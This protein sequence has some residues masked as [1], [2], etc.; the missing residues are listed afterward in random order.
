MARLPQLGGDDG[1]WGQILN[2]FLAVE[3]I[4]SDANPANIGK[5]RRGTEIDQKYAIP[6]DSN[7]NVLGIPESDL[8]PAV[9][10]KLNNVGT[11]VPPDG[12]IT[13]VK[14]KVPTDPS[15][16]IAQSKIAN[17]V[18]DLQG[19]APANDYRLSDARLIVRQTA[20]NFQSSRVNLNF[21]AGSGITLS[22]SDDPDTTKDQ[23]NLQI[24]ATSPGASSP[25]PWTN[26]LDFGATG[27]GA[28]DDTAAFQDAIASLKTIPQRGG[29][30]YA[31][32]GT[33]ILSQELLVDSGIEVLGDGIGVTNLKWPNEIS[34]ASSST[35]KFGLNMLGPGPDIYGTSVKNLTVIGPYGPR[36][37]GVRQYWTHGIHSNGAAVIRDVE[38]KGFNGGLYVTQDHERFEDMKISNCYYGVYFGPTGTQGSQV[39]T[40]VDLTNNAFASVGVSNDGVIGGV[41]WTSVQFGKGPYAFYKEGPALP[42]RDL[43]LAGQVFASC[44]FDSCGNG[45]MVGTN[46]TQVSYLTMTSCTSSNVFDASQR[47]PGEPTDA[48]VKVGNFGYSRIIASNPFTTPGDQG[49]FQMDAFGG[50]YLDDCG[51][52]VDACA[53]A[54]KQFL[55][56]H[57]GSSTEIRY[58]DARCRIMMTGQTIP[59]WS[60]IE[61]TADGWCQEYA[62]GVPVGVSVLDH[63]GVQ[64]V[65]IVAHE[66]EVK[67]RV[68]TS[69]S[70]SALKY[71][72]PDPVN[73]GCAIEASGPQDGA[74]FA[75][76]LEGQPIDQNDTDNLVRCRLLK[77]G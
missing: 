4:V 76:S 9:I 23:I 18:S 26:V 1:N 13:D 5:L 15:D 7:G 69:Q 56:L 12:S 39:F 3:H 57:Q 38:I 60:L 67:V 72:K 33:Y 40:N 14:V 59:R 66:G 16:P 30:L 22:A 44:T 70:V 47:A 6:R 58:Y 19:K 71:L 49:I 48:M 46:T 55:N 68:H 34:G 43:L 74:V 27:D 41:I 64:G 17:L 8:A 65:A 2:D 75:V 32:R 54:N 63:T 37:L 45:V 77:C 36:Q 62:S 52:A 53:T 25:L 11:N 35:A 20:I 51:A 10:T 21:F 42:S 24:S 73:H 28:T 61:V 29:I 50:S 31:P